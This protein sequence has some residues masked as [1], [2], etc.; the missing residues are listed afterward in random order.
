MGAMN[1]RAAHEA[2]NVALKDQ[3]TDW[4]KVETAMTR[5]EEGYVYEIRYKDIRVGWPWRAE[6]PVDP[7]FI[8]QMEAGEGHGNNTTSPL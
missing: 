5:T 2:I 7:E 8:K 1:L 4:D 6:L 3:F